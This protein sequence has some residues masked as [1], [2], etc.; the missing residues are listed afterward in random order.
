M[1]S[2]L[3]IVLIFSISCKFLKAFRWKITL[4]IP[5]SINFAAAKE[6]GS[7]NDDVQG[8]D[9]DNYD[10]YLLEATNSTNF[11]GKFFK[12]CFIETCENKHFLIFT[13]QPRDPSIEEQPNF[14]AIGAFP[15]SNST[16][17][18]SN[19]TLP[20]TIPTSPDPINTTSEPLKPE[21]KL[22]L[23]YL[24]NLLYSVIV[25]VQNNGKSSIPDSPSPSIQSE[26]PESESDPL[27]SSDSE[28][29]E[30]PSSENRLELS[31]SS[32]KNLKSSSISSETPSSQQMN[33]S[34]R[35]TSK[36]SSEISTSL[37]GAIKLP[38]SASLDDSTDP[39]E[40]ATARPCKYTVPY[41]FSNKDP[42][43]PDYYEDVGVPSLDSP[44]TGSS[45][46]A[47][48][49]S[50]ILNYSATISS[51]QSSSN[52][53][54][55][56]AAEPFSTQLSS[57]ES[58][59]LSILNNLSSTSSK[60]ENSINSSPRFN[61]QTKAD[62][63]S[64]DD[65]SEFNSSKSFK[66]SASQSQASKDS[67]VY[68]DSEIA[69]LTPPR[70][71]NGSISSKTSVS[72]SSAEA[73][74]ATESQL[75]VPSSSEAFQDSS[76]SGVSETIVDSNEL[77]ENCLVNSEEVMIPKGD[78]SKSCSGNKK[79]VFFKN[80]DGS[81]SCCCAWSQTLDR[82]DTEMCNKNITIIKTVE[83]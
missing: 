65:G 32:W 23:D 10:E 33:E 58:K 17:S 26:T 42:Y 51:A 24:C 30:S 57:K 2:Q 22:L 55:S 43:Y 45:N 83:L 39:N 38:S 74:N 72:K 50:K 8:A 15:D 34:I 7:V 68:T 25:Q 44:A 28:A 47:D 6:I 64:E 80:N 5:G 75:Q 81:M 41:D 48:E 37:S 35:D 3:C 29:F 14:P 56:T 16:F 4:F 53:Q 46:K 1:K 69:S 66:T 52:P 76:I 13:V 31:E 59:A 73:L 61:S 62:K 63:S 18:D 21:N 49:E 9:G 82:N 40:E 71:E 11:Q 12:N 27:D 70:N 79:L 54:N 19:S 77:L 78:C 60:S 67:T 20:D 36:I